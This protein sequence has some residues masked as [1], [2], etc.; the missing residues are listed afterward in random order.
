M[1]S[2][3]KELQA[4]VNAVDQ[5]LLIDVKQ[6]DRHL[7]LNGIGPTDPV[8]LCAF[9]STN[10]FVPARKGSGET[11]YDW[12]AVTAQAAKGN[13]D[14][15]ALSAHL[16]N[17]DGQ[18]KNLGYISCPGGSAI[19][20]RAEIKEGRVLFVEIDQE[21]LDKEYQARVWLLA[22]LPDP[23]YQ[24]DTGSKSIW[25]VWV[26]DRMVSA[27]QITNGRQ[28]LSKA[29]EDATGIK[30]DHA[31]HSPHQP[32]RLAGGLHPKTGRRSVLINVTGINY[33]FDELMAACPE[34]EEKKVLISSDN[35]FPD[36]RDEIV[37]VGEYPDSSDLDCPVPLR[38]ALSKKTQELIKQGQNPGEFKGRAL[39]AYRLSL[40]LRAAEEQFR[41]LGYDVEGDPQDLF[42]EFCTNSDLLGLQDL[43][44]CRQRHF[45]SAGDCGQGE[46]SK[47]ALRRA[48]ARWAQDQR[49]WRYKPKFGKEKGFDKKNVTAPFTY[50]VVHLVDRSLPHRL[51]FFQRYVRR[52]VREHRNS[53]RRAVYLKDVLKK[54]G[55]RTLIKDEHLVAMTMEAH[56]DIQ[57]NVFNPLNA[58]QRKKM[59]MPI[60]KWLIPDAV[61]KGDLTIV[62]GAPKVGK[63]NFAVDMARAIARGESWLTFKPAEPAYVILIT[64]D[65]S[66][67]DSAKQMDQLK[68]W[69]EPNLSWSRR[70]RLTE[71]QMDLLLQEI[72]QHPGCVV[73]LDSLRSATRSLGCDENSPELGLVLYD[74][75]AAVT[76]A[77]G[78]LILV[79]HG[80]KGQN[81]TGGEALSGHNSIAGSANTIWTLHQ[82]ANKDGW[83]DKEKP[84]RRAVREA[85]SG[86][87]CDIVV[88]M[89]KEGGFI[90]LGSYGDFLSKQAEAQQEEATEKA[91]RNAPAAVKAAI[92]KLAEVRQ[93]GG[94]GMGILVVMKAIEECDEEVETLVNLN[95]GEKS[96]HKQIERWFKDLRIKGIT[97]SVEEPGGFGGK[98]R[99]IGWTLTDK[100]LELARNELGA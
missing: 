78:S 75:K 58:D 64:D 12:D 88:T 59:E 54:L 62:G 52:T 77:G 72:K 27:D 71:R 98:S 13:R 2:L 23:T 70:M 95:K 67:G 81:S 73:F 36:D 24:L 61:P 45:M 7:A 47:S 29:I 39:T 66:D 85:R 28:R 93:K 82:I 46:L 34:I 32:A 74:V 35:L 17:S 21:G 37:R 84:E 11:P 90:N 87:G 55:L 25:H 79:H 41:S 3:S 44:L 63:T 49:L 16:T 14:Y 100:G 60:I 94:E 91:L 26:L 43:D 10:R 48:I 57:G 69:T 5:P 20:K 50:E 22:Q 51:D 33:Q 56:D 15:K 80:H 96:K 53:F 83:I 97:E 92:L 6:A 31:L 9:G 99:L 18:S 30:T 1:L 86:K 4:L 40:T 42:D 8:I 76:D 65:Q 68:L 19:K 89:R 38:L